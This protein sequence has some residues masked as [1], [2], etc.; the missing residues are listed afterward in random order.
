MIIHEVIIHNFRSIKDANIKLKN[1]SLL[2]G[3]NNAGKTNII[4]AIRIFFN[5]N[6]QF[7]EERDF[8]KF[9]VDDDQESWIEIHF[10]TTDEEQN[11]LKENYRTDNNILKVRRYLKS[12][13]YV[14]S[15][16]SNIY[17][18]E[19]CKLSKE[20]FYITKGSKNKLGNITYIPPVSTSDETFKLSG[21]SPFRNIVNFVFNGA[22]LNSPSFK[23]LNESIDE[24]N[25][26]VMGKPAENDGT[27]L[28]D[29]KKDM[30]E[31]IKSWG[32]EFGMEINELQPQEIVKSLFSYH[33][34][35]KTL[36]KN[37]DINSVGDGLQRYLIYNLIKLSSKYVKKTDKG[38][39]NI[40]NN[41]NLL[42][43]EEPE[44]FLHLSQQIELNN[45]LAKL[46][47][48]NN[49]ILIS[50][51]SPVFVSKNIADLPSLVSVKKNI[52]T[53][54]F[55]LDSNDVDKLFDDNSSFFKKCYNIY[56]DPE[57]SKNLKD[58]IK[59]HNLINTKNPNKLNYDDK[60]SEESLKYMLWID[61]ERASSLFAKHVIICE[62]PTEKIAFNYLIDT[63]SCFPCKDVY[64]LDAM[65]KY[66]I[67]R[68][69]N[70]FG[71]LGISHSVLYDKDSNAEFQE[72][73]NNF[74]TGNKNA[75][76]KTIETF[77]KDIE[78]F[79]GIESPSRKSRKPRKDQ[80]PLNLLIK[81]KNNEISDKKINE[82]M[83]KL[84]R[85]CNHD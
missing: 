68:Y 5:D 85:L 81:L 73:V 84:K 36:E 78:G 16:Q 31:N 71:K 28:N 51:H 64:I 65:G 10:K 8:P 2:V 70:L 33:L 55:Q 32:V 37:V 56:N 69:M 75:Y 57:A 43:F 58:A 13:N 49:Q 1:Y 9:H 6:I 3:E 19:N 77:K 20:Q 27:S 47:D 54:T 46:A 72:F 14:K 74:I 41:F 21:P 24:F 45:S 82:L 67:H 61:S 26:N 22:I 44:L 23:L 80:K 76:T 52:E 25:K 11:E 53:K 63:L 18:Y 59:R 48:D 34:T 39:N 7:E 30:D 42:L 50:T 12:D 17:G 4:T 79:L 35:E 66:N 62:G 83:D 38:N 15:N 29:I 40:F 60:L